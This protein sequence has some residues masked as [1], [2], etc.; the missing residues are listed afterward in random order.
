MRGF[1]ENAL[2]LVCDMRNL[3][4]IHNFSCFQLV[5]TAKSTHMRAVLFSFTNFIS[6]RVFIQFRIFISVLVSI[7]FWHLI[8]VQFLFRFSLRIS[9][10]ILFSSRIFNHFISVFILF[11]VEKRRTNWITKDII[12]FCISFKFSFVRQTVIFIFILFTF[13]GQFKF[14]FSFT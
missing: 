10:F 3:S 2:S 12:V 5:E 4:K 1:L 13:F 6:V 7:L 14:E 8:F 11:W 9:V